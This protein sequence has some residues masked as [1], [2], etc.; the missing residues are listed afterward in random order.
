MELPCLCFVGLGVLLQVLAVTGVALCMLQGSYWVLRVLPCVCFKG[1]TGCY[2]CCP[3]YV[4]GSSSST[5]VLL[6]VTGV[7][8]CMFQ[9][10]SSP[11]GGCDW[12]CPVYV[13]GVLLGVTGVALCMFQGSYWVLWVLPCLCFKGLTG[14]CPVYVSGVLLGVT[15]VSLC[16]LQGSRVVVAAN[17]QGTVKILEV[18]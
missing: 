9:G 3:V 12:C 16:M 13:A 4:A 6:G 18:V 15:G 2:G 7:A 11:T 8:L 17:S 5:G 10:S 14:C 1:L